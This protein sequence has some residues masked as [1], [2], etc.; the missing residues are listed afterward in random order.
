[1]PAADHP[2]HSFMPAQPLSLLTDFYQL[3]MAYGYWKS[4]KGEDRAIFH[5]F[6][7]KHPFHGGY[8]I[9]AGLGYVI[10]YLQNLRFTEDDLAYLAEQRTVTGG[11]LFE[12]A[13][14][15]YLRRLQ[16]TCDIYGM[17]EGT[18]A[19]PQEPILRVEGPIIQCQLLETALLNSINFQTLIATK[20]ARINHAA[21]GDTVM[22]FGLRRAHGIDGGMA[23]SRAAYIGGCASTSNVL[24]GKQFGIPV[25][26][27][28]AHS[29]VMAFEEEKEAFEAYAEALPDNCVFLVDTYQ[30]EQGTKAAIEVGLALKAKGKKLAAVRI[31]SGDLAYFSTLA[32]QM[33]DDAGLKDTK[34]VASNDLDEYII[35]SLKTE[36]KAPIDSWGVGTKLVTA[37]D[38][39]ALGA[40]YKMSKIKP[41][42]AEWRD[43]V[44]LSEQAIK[45]NNPGQLQ[46]R[47]YFN[48]K[49]LLAGDLI[50]DASYP[51][52]SDPVMIDPADATRQKRP[53]KKAE[54]FEDLLQPIFLNG[55][56]VYHQPD[57]QD[58]RTFVRRQMNL[59]DASNKRLVNPHVYAVGLEQ[60]L[61]TRKRNLILQLRERYT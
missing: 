57:L 20:S 41:K 5:L 21:Q 14:L 11:A 24:A 31:D 2:S 26:G 15:D 1:M 16:F 3:T 45:V 17:P 44:K 19:F 55:K 37:F 49:G 47:R 7:R 52:P 58:I 13:F 33:L 30:T 10:D 18:L 40:V 36:Q 56:I 48:G 50:Y 22:E 51:V 9:T 6:F 60:G 43:T 29:W 28:H 39:P 38:Q 35:H 53:L 59:L 8:T 42:G 27:T 46:V 23:A 12:A 32:R 54:H 34:I 25:A 61:Y 4:G